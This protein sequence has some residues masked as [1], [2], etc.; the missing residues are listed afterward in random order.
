MLTGKEFF[1]TLK[2]VSGEQ[3]MAVLEDE[4]ELHI[5]LEF[6][7]VMRGRID[8]ERGREVMMAAPFSQFS[9]ASSFILDKSHVVFIKKLHP[10]FIENYL[11]F[12]K[13]YEIVAFNSS[14][15]EPEEHL[16][17]E[18]IKARLDALDALRGNQPE[19][20]EEETIQSTFIVGNDTKH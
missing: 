9:D 14:E 18:D 1:V 15:E 20:D 3:L 4:D 10:A 13:S 7:I 2:L 6:P 16:T 19:V 12:V 8:T 17:V 11:E 5:K